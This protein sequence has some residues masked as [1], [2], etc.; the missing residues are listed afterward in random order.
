MRKVRESNEGNNCRAGT[1]ISV[2]PREWILE[3]R[4]EGPGTVTSGDGRIDCPGTCSATYKEGESAPSLRALHGTAS[5]EITWG[6]EA[7]SCT[8][9]LGSS[10]CQPDIEGQGE[11]RRVSVTFH[12]VQFIVANPYDLTQGERI[13][14]FRSCAGHDYSGQNVSGE[15]ESNRS[16][17][18]YFQ[19]VAALAGSTGQVKV[20]SPFDG[21]VVAVMTEQVPRGKQVWLSPDASPGWTVRLLNVDP[22]AGVDVGAAVRAGD[23]IGHGNLSTINGQQANDIDIGLEY[24]PRFDSVF[25]HMSDSVLTQYSAKGIT[26]ENVV[27]SKAARD[28]DPCDFSKPSSDSD[29]VDLQ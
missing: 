1:T 14:K 21:K 6:D 10:D 26:R 12:T 9:A 19:P 16:M 8:S 7:S 24:G 28:A 25:F 5:G 20:F 3:V 15:T 17:K 2:V 29:W 13:S 4:V 18:H 11:T 22:V 23:L 27:I